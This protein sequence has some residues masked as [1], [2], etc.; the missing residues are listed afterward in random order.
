MFHFLR[1][2]FSWREKL[3]WRYE[4]EF[5][6]Y[7]RTNPVTDSD[8]FYRYL[9]EKAKPYLNKSTIAL[10]TGCGLG[11]FV[12][13]IG[14]SVVDRVYGIDTNQLLVDEAINIHEHKRKE[15]IT[16]NSKGSCLFL[17]ESVLHLPFENEFFSFVSCINLIDRVTDPKKVMDECKRVL[18]PNGILFFCDPYDWTNSKTLKERQVDNVKKLLNMKQWVILKEKDNIPYILFINKRRTT[19]YRSHLLMLKKIK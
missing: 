18:Q 16:Y 13:D 10:D 17:H 11:R 9:Y 14:N 7:L 6:K 2:R 12:M 4:I 19:H 8:P 1:N 5:G 15:K 3:Q